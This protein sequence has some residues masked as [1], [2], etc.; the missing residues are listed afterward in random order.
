MKDRIEPAPIR[1]GASDRQDR[2]DKFDLEAL[3]H[4]GRMFAHPSD[5]V[6]D[7]DLS[8]A[9]KRAILASWASDA[10]AVEAAP[11]LRFPPGSN[12]PVQFDEVM[13]ALRML[14]GEQHG[15][16]FPLPVKHRPGLWARLR[17]AGSSRGSSS[18]TNLIH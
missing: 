13:D 8:L 16:R 15:E 18:S 10:C 14:E 9:E 4:P 12:T 3:L 6:R 17:Q 7:P 5:V 1:V 2:D 11:A